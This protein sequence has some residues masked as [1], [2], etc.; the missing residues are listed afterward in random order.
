ML[1]AFSLYQQYSKIEQPFEH[2][3]ERTGAGI[4]HAT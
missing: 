4:F 3:V 2:K 1:F